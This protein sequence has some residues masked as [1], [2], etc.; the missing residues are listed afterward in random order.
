MGATDDQP[1]N[2]ET[3]IEVQG[4]RERG[5]IL[6]KLME[7]IL[8]GEID[9]AAPDFGV[10]E[11]QRAAQDAMLAAGVPVVMAIGLLLTPAPVTAALP[12]WL[13]L[14]VGQPLVVA[15]VLSL[16]ATSLLAFRAAAR[17]PA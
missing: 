14:V 1:R 4:G 12:S 9:D 8:S 2:P 17:R 13:A 10:L 11:R 16:A 6:H 7:E 15:V 5:L 3:T